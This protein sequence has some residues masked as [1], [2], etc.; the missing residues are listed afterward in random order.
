M[1]NYY[2]WRYILDNYLKF[3]QEF[4]PFSPGLEVKYAID[5]AREIGVEPHLAGGAFNGETLAGLETE[6]AVH[7]FNLMYN[8]F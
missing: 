1:H 4:H 5:S 2:L 8:I 3:N 7:P 6:T